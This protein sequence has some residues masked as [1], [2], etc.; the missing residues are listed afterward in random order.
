MGLRLC[1]KT[2]CV[3]I[4]NAL[5]IVLFVVVL[6]AVAA[7]VGSLVGLEAHLRHLRLVP[8]HL[9]DL[10]LHH[11][12]QIQIH[13]HQIQIHHHQIQNPDPPPSNPDPPP[14]NP[15]LPSVTASG[16]ASII[17]GESVTFTFTSSPPPAGLMNVSVELSQS[18]SFIDGSI[19][20][21]TV[22]IDPISGV[23]VLTVGTVDD[24]VDEPNGSVA[25]QVQDGTRYTVGQ[26]SSATVTV[27]DND[28]PPPS[29]PNPPPPS[30]PNPPST[31]S[32]PGSSN[33]PT[34][35]IAKGLSPIIEGE[36]ATFTLT[37]SPKPSATL[38]VRVDVSQS[39][40]FVKGN[41]G[42]KYVSIGSS[43]T[44][45][46]SLE[47]DN[48]KRDEGHGTITAQLEES[49]GYSIGSLSSASV[50]VLDNDDPSVPH[51]GAPPPSP[52]VRPRLHTVSSVSF[53]ITDGETDT[54]SIGV[55][56]TGT[57]TIQ[58][59]SITTN[60]AGLSLDKTSFN[61]TA[62]S[63]EA[64]KLTF[65]STT[66]GTRSGS[67]TVVTSAGTAT[68]P[69]SV[70]VNPIV[71]L[72]TL[73][74]GKNTTSCNRKVTFNLTVSLARDATSLS[75][76]VAKHASGFERD[77]AY[78]IENGPHTHSYTHTFSNPGTTETI[79]ITA[80]VTSGKRTTNPRQG[81]LALK[82]TSP[83]DSKRANP[84]IIITY[85]DLF[86]LAD[87]GTDTCSD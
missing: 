30:N 22:G 40:T 79:T 66:T 83:T 7:V 23:G 82:I 81:G 54:K 57:G 65:T 50:S 41:T 44:A 35:T 26:P 38:N 87:P 42:T 1:L 9:H 49:P 56:N 75:V 78:D 61:V 29:N 18:G 6:L 37:A 69:V 17:E 60:V 8:N 67:I 70:T 32:N 10:S 2:H 27:N 3:C 16:P 47:T 76:T 48:D 77:M 4:L 19:G 24:G 43:G 84:Y 72:A 12:H 25:V 58:V 64:V 33:N 45:T 15:D 5:R 21:K 34:V 74:N 80:K 51:I 71:T 28:G 68:I 11:H 13:H 73:T 46:L 31:P 63:S 36:D 59:T 20:S 52:A 55:G 39:G 86:T 53:T 85:V 62:N 14:S